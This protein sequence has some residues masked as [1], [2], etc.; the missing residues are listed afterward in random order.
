M[1]GYIDKF[2]IRRRSRDRHKISEPVIDGKVNVPVGIS[3]CEIHQEVLGPLIN[4]DLVPVLV[5]LSAKP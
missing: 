4:S 5:R 3:E 2:I 1:D